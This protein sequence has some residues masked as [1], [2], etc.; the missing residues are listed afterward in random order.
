MLTTAHCKIRL[1]TLPSNIK[2]VQG[3]K[4]GPCVVIMGAVHGNERLGKAVVESLWHEIQ[5]ENLYGELVLIIGNPVAYAQHQRC[6]HSDLNRLFGA[7]IEILKKKAVS[8]LNIEEKR[9]IEIAPFLEKADY[10]LD[11]H[12]TM[13]PSVPFVYCEKTKAHLKFA[14]VFETEYVVFPATHCRI[15]ELASSTDNYVDQHGGLG[16]TYEAGWLEGQIIFSEAMTKTYKF[17]EAVGS[18]QSSFANSK[19]SQKIPKK[20]EIN[21][22]VI[23]Q[24]LH[25]HF[26]KD[27]SNFD[28][29]KKGEIIAEDQGKIYRATKVSFVIFP[30]RKIIPGTPACYLGNY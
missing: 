8:T 28:I 23:P 24:S 16:F 20:V 21:D 30:K 2:C 13:K 18:L 26:K 14:Y 3:K 22:Y 4:N 5:P 17:L 9:A 6:I 19:K 15:S 25:F 1:K 7:Q 11:I 12:A 29:V 10:L 27:F